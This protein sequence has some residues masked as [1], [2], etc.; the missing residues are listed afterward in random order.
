MKMGIEAPLTFGPDEMARLK[1][2]VLNAES[3][4]RSGGS[5]RYVEGVRDAYIDDLT[6]D[7][8][9][10]RPIRI[11][12]ACGNGTAGAFAEDVLKRIGAE[13]IPVE[14]DLNWSFPNYNPNPESLEMLHAMRD[15]C[16]ENKAEVALG[17]DGDGDR[18]GVV[19]NEGEEI[20]ADKVGVILARD[21]SEQYENAKFVVDV[22]STGLFNTDPVL[23]GNGA[24]TEYLSLIHI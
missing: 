19:D 15:A 18:C 9:L 5:Y 8:I 24:K 13:V 16:L 7:I 3:K 4:P 12:A 23:N 11:V 17:F 14:C 1:D 2:I 10:S 20:F 22:K 6:K 21:L